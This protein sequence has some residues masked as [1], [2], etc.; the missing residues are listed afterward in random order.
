MAKNQRSGA[1]PNLSLSLDADKMQMQH[2]LRYMKHAPTKTASK[3]SDN[4]SQQR[5]LKTEGCFDLKTSGSVKSPGARGSK[6]NSIVGGDTLRWG[7]TCVT[8]CSTGTTGEFKKIV[9][10]CMDQGAN[11]LRI[12]LITFTGK[13]GHHGVRIQQEKNGK[14]NQPLLRIYG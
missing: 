8:N 2:D 12:Q 14:D 3:Q 10:P 9:D 7:D 4:P 13:M 5:W 11:A 1:H 6:A